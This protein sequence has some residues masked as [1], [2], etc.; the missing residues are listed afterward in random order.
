MNLFLKK[1]Y[2]MCAKAVSSYGFT[3]KSNAFLRICNDV[4]Q[5]FY[6]EGLGRYSYGK[7]YR[8]GFLVSPLCKPIDMEILRVRLGASTYYLK[9]L[10]G[11][12]E[13]CWCCTSSNTDLCIQEI[14]TYLKNYLMPFFDAC[15]SCKNA[16]SALISL[17][18]HLHRGQNLLDSTKFYL[19]LKCQDW[20]LALQ[21]R[22]ALYQ[23]NEESYRVGMEQAVF[24]EQGQLRREKELLQLQEEIIRLEERDTEYFQKIIDTNE[25]ASI[26][27]LTTYIGIE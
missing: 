24:S 21:S 8:I 6:I 13:D 4:F 11:G 26:E 18:Q 3:R 7:E 16:L 10:D 20:D 17:E 9:Q 1:Y 14:E 25:K 2:A 12:Q 22:R 5:S 23:Q 27:V 15:N 19:A